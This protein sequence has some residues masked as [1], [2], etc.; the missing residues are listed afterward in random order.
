[1]TAT[2]WL[3]TFAAIHA[4]YGALQGYAS[5]IGAEAPRWQAGAA[6]RDFVGRMW[7]TVVG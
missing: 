2:G 3:W 7:P 5:G 4:V 1:M 6:F